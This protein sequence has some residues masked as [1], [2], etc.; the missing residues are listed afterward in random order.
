MA[1]S[2]APS[3]VVLLL[4]TTILKGLR[5]VLRIGALRAWGF[6]GLVVLRIMRPSGFVVS[7]VWPG[8]M[9]QPFRS[10]GRNHHP[11][12]VKFKGLRIRVLRAWV[13]WFG[14]LKGFT[15]EDFGVEGLACLDAP[16]VSFFLTEPP[17]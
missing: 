11:G 5:G 10:S 17:S 14:G 16:A 2:D 15:R 7:G 6:K 4:G 12:R 1:C 3:R 13:L 8:R 9:L